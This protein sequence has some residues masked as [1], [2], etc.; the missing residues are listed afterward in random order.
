MTVA[1]TPVNMPTHAHSQGYSDIN[2]MIPEIVAGVQFSKGPYFA[3][4]GDF[5]TA[6]SSN[7]TY[8]TE[9]DR[10]IVHL[11]KGTFGFGRVLLAASPKVGRGHL[12]AAMEA[13]TNAGPWTVPD[14]YQ[15]FNGVV[16]YS[17]GDQVNGLSITAATSR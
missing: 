16:R 4:Q 6:G 13:S 8:A 15:K 2:F 9:L 3:D 14:S 1:G 11:E 10:P 12:L 7:I 17:Q 5:A